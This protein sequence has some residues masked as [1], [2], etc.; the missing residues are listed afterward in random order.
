ML[1]ESQLDFFFSLLH[2][3]FELL[4]S[5]FLLAVEHHVLEEMREAGRARTLVARSDFEEEIHG[6][7]G[8]AMILLNQDFHPVRQRARL[9]AVYLPEHEYGS[10]EGKEKGAHVFNVSEEKRGDFIIS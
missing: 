6:D 2:L 3:N 9:D 5:I 1:N 10:G 7:V 4:R 8:N